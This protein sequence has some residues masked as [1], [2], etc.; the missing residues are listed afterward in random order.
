MHSLQIIKNSPQELVAVQTPYSASF[1]SVLG[2]VVALGFCAWFAYT[3]QWRLLIIPALALLVFWGLTLIPSAP[4][5]HLQ[6]DRVGH[7]VISEARRGDAVVTSFS[8]DTIE[9]SGADMQFNR[10]ASTIVLIRKDGS[11]LYPLGEQQ[12]QNEP[13][14]YVVLN[15]LRSVIADSSGKSQG[16]Q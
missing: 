16:R 2:I 13:D 1:L 4:T 3:R 15:V 7:R 6:V 9:L 11:L 10:G 12:L 14:Q 5:Y 8:V